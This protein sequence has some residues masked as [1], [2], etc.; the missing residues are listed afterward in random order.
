MSER[1]KRKVGDLLVTNTAMATIA[2][3]L[4][5]ELMMVEGK[6]D[7]IEELRNAVTRKLKNAEISGLGY[8]DQTKL[9]SRTLLVINDFFDRQK[10]KI[11]PPKS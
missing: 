4:M 10:E 6:K 7:S 3:V 1:L 11:N 5:D 9:V 8:E 2:L